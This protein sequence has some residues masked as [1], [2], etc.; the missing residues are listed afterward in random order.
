MDLS[1]A[2]VACRMWGRAFATDQAELQSLAHAA[3]VGCL[4]S[5]GIHDEGI[6]LRVDTSIEGD[7]VAQE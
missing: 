6:E 7:P 3:M 2:G 5:I 4:A 1:L